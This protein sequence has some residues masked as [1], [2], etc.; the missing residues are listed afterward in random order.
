MDADPTRRPIRKDRYCL[1]DGN[2]YFEIDVYPFWTD[3]AVDVEVDCLIFMQKA[4]MQ[5]CEKVH[6][7]ECGTI[8]KRSERPCR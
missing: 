3:K 1:T 5:K 4:G 7:S 6:E 2:Q 8:Y